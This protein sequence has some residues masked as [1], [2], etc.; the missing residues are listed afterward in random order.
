MG[1]HLLDRPNNYVGQ[2]RME[3]LNGIN[4][5]SKHRQAF[6]EFPDVQVATEKGFE[7]T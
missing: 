4:R 1:P 7:P 3:W 2:L 5:G 6:R